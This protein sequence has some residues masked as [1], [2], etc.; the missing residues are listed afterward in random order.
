M[1]SKE[2]KILLLDIADRIER[3]R[4]GFDHDEMDAETAFYHA[5]VTV[6]DAIRAALAAI[7]AEA[8]LPMEGTGNDR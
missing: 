7:A 2:V 3:S 6:A 4:H 5:C 8:A 1:T